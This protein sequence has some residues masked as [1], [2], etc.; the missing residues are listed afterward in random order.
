MGTSKSLSTPS[1]GDWS[2]LKEDIAYQLGGS[3]RCTAAA[4]VGRTMQA[5]GGIGSM[6]SA[7]VSGRST[8]GGGR[9]SGGGSGTGARAS[10]AVLELGG[11][12][13]SV[14]AQGLGQALDRLGLGELRDRPAAEV[15]ARVAEHL[16]SRSD[17][18]DRTLLTGALRDT[19]LEVANLDDSVAY[20]DLAES[21]ESFLA[22]N[23]VE[24]LVESFLA[25][26]VYDQVWSLV[27]QW[28][29]EKSNSNPDTEALR[30]SV[31]SAC[32][33]LARDAM[34]SLKEDGRLDSVDWFGTD[35]AALA[36]DIVS[37]VER[38]LNSAAAEGA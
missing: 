29:L 18:L 3:P 1:G 34:G 27:E 38:R 17:G 37:D 36:R 10:R 4:L 22:A 13:T 30:S 9:G 12:G 19:L 6:S 11:F 25:N 33:Q 2:P 14:A 26:L 16:S 32:R 15:V 24:G 8:G 23:G 7:G 5:A 35:G 28:V 20:Q 21:L 31:E